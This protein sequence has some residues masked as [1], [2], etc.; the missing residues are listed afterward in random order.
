MI[1]HNYC[2]HSTSFGKLKFFFAIVVIFICSLLIYPGTVNASTTTS[3]KYEQRTIHNPDG[4]GKFYMGREIAH[5]MGHTGAMWL[6][7]PSREAEEQP[8]KIVNALELKPSDVVADIGA[9]TGYL[10]FLMAPTLTQGKVLAVDIQ[11]EML[12]IINFFKGEKHIDNVEPILAT[13]NSPNLLSESIDLAVMVDAYHE[14]E[15]PYEVMSG[16]AKALKPGGRVALVEYRGENPFIMIKGLHKM[17]QKQVKKEMQA[18]GLTWQ[19][20]K[21]LLPQQHL[22][23]FTKA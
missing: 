20:T 21:N 22:M 17:T 10:S 14:F 7:R 19:E 6:E 4:I 2:T 8:S 15:Y 5:V 16:I 1:V 9:G 18:V 3:T 23:L 11:P 12:D 13:L